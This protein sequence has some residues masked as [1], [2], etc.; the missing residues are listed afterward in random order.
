MTN[1][2]NSSDYESESIHSFKSNESQE[3]QESELDSNVN[4]NS[5]SEDSQDSQESQENQEEFNFIDPK[6]LTE[7]KL[8]KFQAKLEAT[9][10]I[11]LSKIPPFMKP[12]KL[13]SLLSKSGKLGRIYLAPEDPKITAKRKKYR[14]N[15]RQNYIEGWVEFLDKKEAR[16]TAERLNNSKIGGKKRS[17]YYDDIWCMKYLPRFKWNNLTEQ[18]AYELKVK[19]QKLKTE[20]AQSKR[21]NKLYLQN[22]DK[23]KMIQGMQEKRKA[24]GVSLDQESLVKRQFKQR[25]VIQNEPQVSK[26]SQVLSQLFNSF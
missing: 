12:S 5:D 26:T 17:Y 8:A 18:I 22:V 20:L 9:G 1:D 11:Y 13:R 10:V 7:K 23:A 16:M 6:P 4:F 14:H 25:K 24:K 2:L 15:K 3:S 19:E 21:E